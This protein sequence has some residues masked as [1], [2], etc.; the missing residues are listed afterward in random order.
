[1]SKPGKLADDDEMD[2]DNAVTVQT[3][4]EIAGVIPDN[5]INALLQSIQPRKNGAVYEPIAKVVEDIVA[6]GW[7]ATQVLLQLYDGIM[8]D[9]KIS[10]LRK[11][12]I[13]MVFSETDKR[14]IDGADEHLTIL[15]LALRIAEN[16]GS[17]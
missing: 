9:E 12:R 8:S 1:M 11:S 16:L 2:I 7:S 13:A 6:D 10:D 5:T 4:E 15:D 3:I 14:L 17:G